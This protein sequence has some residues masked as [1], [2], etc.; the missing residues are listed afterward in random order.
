MR[1]LTRRRRERQAQES[2]PG[3]RTS[4]GLARALTWVSD[5][6]P[7]QASPPS[8]DEPRA[9]PRPASI[10]ITGAPGVGKSTFIGR[11]A[12]KLRQ[13]G[14]RVAVIAVDPTSPITGGSLLGDRL[15]M[16]QAE[17]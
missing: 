11:L 1:D 10:G 6:R 17:P 4:A 3:T 12:R 5:G 9:A 13:R 16:M 2:T 14:K 15:R 7:V 8:A